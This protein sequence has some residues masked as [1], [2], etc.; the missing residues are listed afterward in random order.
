V[1]YGVVHV[2]IIVKDWNRGKKQEFK[3]RKTFKNHQTT[4]ENKKEK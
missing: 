1:K 4:N 3:D 2:G